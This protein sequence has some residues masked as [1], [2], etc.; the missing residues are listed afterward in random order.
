M[1]KEVGARA[2]ELHEFNIL[3]ECTE[4][5]CGWKGETRH[6]G[7]GE[8]ISKVGRNLGGM[9]PNEVSQEGR[10]QQWFEFYDNWV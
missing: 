7:G 9:V 2:P 4:E 1:Q 10:S 5:L 3:E 6:G 8:T